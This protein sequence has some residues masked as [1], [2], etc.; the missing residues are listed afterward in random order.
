M[1]SVFDMMKNDELNIPKK[2]KEIINE[3]NETMESSKNENKDI[4]QPKKG[5]GRPRKEK[6]PEIEENKKKVD[7]KR[8]TECEIIFE[9]NRLIDGIIGFDI[10]KKNNGIFDTNVN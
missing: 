8:D 9:K 5:R 6:K 1:R 7:D 10:K 4:I 2:S 3:Y